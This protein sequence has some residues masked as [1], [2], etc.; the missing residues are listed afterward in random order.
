M[1]TEVNKGFIQRL[2]SEGERR[3]D[4]SFDEFRDLEIETGYAGNAEGSAL[5]DLGETRVLVGV[6]METGDPFPDS[7]KEGALM[8]NCELD[9]K[10]SPEFETGPPR[11]QATEIARVID[12]GI[13][14]S[15]TIDVE[16]L[17]IEEGETVWMV[18]VDID[19]LNDGG[20]IMDA[21]GIGAIAALYDTTV[22]ELGEDGRP[23]FGTDA[24]DL[25]LDK[26]PVP[27]TVYKIGD[28]MMF[29]AEYREETAADARLTVT[30]FDGHIC[31]MQKGG[32]GN[33]K[34]QEVLDAA[35]MAMEK[36]EELRD[37]VR[38]AIGA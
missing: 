22:P 3:D 11:E 36:G 17:C 33:F 6:K 24:G 4:R 16:S 20:N 2:A 12:R 14:E 13:R 23:E 15:E 35:E 21:A 38:D 31:A 34:T 26:L 25:D 10:A 1:I 37:Q 32:E 8:V 27:V 7:P 29:D 28:A 18:K 30:S 9:P 19:V 5:V